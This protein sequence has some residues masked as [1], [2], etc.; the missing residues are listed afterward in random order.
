MI[1]T[2]DESAAASER[3]ARE[4]PSPSLDWVATSPDDWRKWWTKQPGTCLGNGERGE[5]CRMTERPVRAHVRGLVRTV[6]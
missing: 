3:T 2:D 4:A 6:P 1:S 5:V